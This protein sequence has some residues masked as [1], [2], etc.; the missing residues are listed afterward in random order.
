MRY[1]MILNKK[2][3]DIVCANTAPKYPPTPEGEVIE[4][5]EIGENEMVSLGMMYENGVFSGDY[6]Q[7]AEKAEPTQLDKIEANLD[8]LVLL[9]S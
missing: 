4:A 2:I 7:K 6:Q 1:A 5:V 9:N 3:I 8:Y